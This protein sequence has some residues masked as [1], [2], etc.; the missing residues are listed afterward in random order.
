MSIK[1]CTVLIPNRSTSMLFILLLGIQIL[2]ILCYKW[3]TYAREHVFAVK[4][5]S[6][7]EW[8]KIREVER[9]NGLYLVRFVILFYFG[10]IYNDETMT[11]VHRHGGILKTL[12]V[13]YRFASMVV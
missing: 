9:E 10:F 13:T 2:L 12:L 11:R 7:E 6:C 1:K 5:I 3:K 4:K 8:I